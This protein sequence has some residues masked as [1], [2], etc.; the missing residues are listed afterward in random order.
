MLNKGVFYIE[1]INKIDGSS[2][3]E[4]VDSSDAKTAKKRR[5]IH[6]HVG[7]CIENSYCL[8]LLTVYA[9]YWSKC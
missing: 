3:F 8:F 2:Y 5:K 4:E 7:F 9:A 6:L 1:K